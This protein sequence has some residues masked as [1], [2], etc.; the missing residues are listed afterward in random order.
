MKTWQIIL[1]SLLA[2]ALAAGVIL[3]AASPP[4]GQAIQLAAQPTP[5][6]L[7][8]YITGAVRQPGVIALAAGSRV[9]DAIQSAGGL[10]PEADA[11]G[12]NL[13]AP[14]HDGQH[15]VIPRIGETLPTQPASATAEARP[16]ATTQPATPTPAYSADHPLN[17][18][19]ASEAD[20]ETLPS[21]GPTRAQA[22]LTYRETHGAFARI[23]DLL[24]VPGIGPTL[25][26]RIKALITAE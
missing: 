8:V 19:T 23:E 17:L 2:G 16:G 25:F 24:N 20:L 11:S 15:L 26:D 10:A 6:P 3:L 13:A 22:I 1:F 4:R 9:K 5:S 14:V 21:I 18:N 12:I 7:I